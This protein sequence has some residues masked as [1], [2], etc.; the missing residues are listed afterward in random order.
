MI[1]LPAGAT[2]IDFAY[3]IHSAVGN[4]MTGAKVNGRIVG[5]DYQLKSGRLWRSSPPNAKGPSRDW[6]KLA[7]S[8]QARTKIR[9]WFKRE[10]REENVAHGRAM[11]EGEIKRLGLTIAMLTAST[12][13][14]TS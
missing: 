10:K 12:C 2:P 5:F 9:Q 7:K 3:A 13:S 8:N 14:P 6:M 11:F 4:S 1:N